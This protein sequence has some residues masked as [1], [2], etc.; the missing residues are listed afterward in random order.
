MYGYVHYDKTTDLEIKTKININLNI[1]FICSQ[2]VLLLCLVAL[3]DARSDDDIFSI[4][5]LLPPNA[6]VCPPGFVGRPPN[7]RG[8]GYLPITTTTYRPRCPSGQFGVFP[9]CYEPCPAYQ[10]GRPPNCQRT[11]C[12][13]GW[14]G[15]YQPNCRFIP[16]EFGY[17]GYYPHCFK[18]KPYIGC[19]GGQL[20]TYPDNCYTPCPIYTYGRPPNCTR[21]KCPNGWEGE[22]QPDCKYIP[23]CPSDRP[24]IWPNCN[25]MYC[26]ADTVGTY[27]NCR[28]KPGFVGTPPDCKKGNGDENQGLSLY[29][30]AD[31]VG[32]YPDCKCKP[33]FVGSP[34]NCK[35]AELQPPNVGQCP[36]GT[37]GVPPNCKP[38]PGKECPPDKPGTYPDCNGFYCPENTV[39]TYPNCKCKPGFEGTPPDCRI[40]SNRPT[41]TYLP[42]SNNI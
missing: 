38:A 26:P 23:Q 36:S 40:K 17:V 3:V 12:P 35:P 41:D 37:V 2:I 31:S 10:S 21:I 33:G 6:D 9:D 7:C 28:C 32:K 22:Y 4:N 24:G 14:E 18:P 27:P 39:G 29:C 20:G 15:D 19:P 42:P 1:F 25:V 13:A 34:P 5:E 30:P 16:C 8:E 11:G